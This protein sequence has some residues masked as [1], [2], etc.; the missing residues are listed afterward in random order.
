M[1]REELDSL[2]ER[3]RLAL[4]SYVAENG[5]ESDYNNNVVIKITDKKYQFDLGVYNRLTEVGCHELYDEDG[6]TYNFSA[7][8]Y[9]DFCDL[10]DYLLSL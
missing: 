1:F 6:Y 9:K 3:M 5:V 2:Y 7:L 4:S 10:T 8:S